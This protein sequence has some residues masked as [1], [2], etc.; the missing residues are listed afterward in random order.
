MQV[1]EKN[2]RIFMLNVKIIKPNSGLFLSG[3]KVAGGSTGKKS[4]IYN[5][6]SMKKEKTC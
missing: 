2:H 5:V 3:F 1:I 4:I 6:L